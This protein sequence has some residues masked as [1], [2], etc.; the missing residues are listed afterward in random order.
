MSDPEHAPSLG[1]RQ[2]LD[3]FGELDELLAGDAMHELL[4]VG[5]AALALRWEDRLSA[6]VDVVD[7]P[8]PGELQTAIRAVADRH[9]LPPGWLNDSAAAFA[10]NMPADATVV[11]RGA[12]L[13]IRAAGPD[14]LLA[15]KLRA[16]R[17]DDLRDAVQLAAETGRTTRESLYELIYDGYWRGTVI[18][19][20]E[21][22]V[23]EV[24]TALTE[25]D[26][27]FGAYS[28]PSAGDVGGV[29]I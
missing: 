13:V 20:L 26:P 11:Y 8:I 10:P 5:G 23:T 22:F 12:R 1:R 24:L 9:S 6:D 27:S 16:S 17:P 3:L 14:Y 29:D 18:V 4:V 7:V 19:D 28:H 25:N 15:M 2:L 21:E